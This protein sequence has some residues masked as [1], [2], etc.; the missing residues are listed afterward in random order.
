MSLCKSIDAKSKECLFDPIGG[1]G[2]WREQVKAC[3]TYS[4]P[5]YSVRPRSHTKAVNCSPTK[6]SLN[7]ASEMDKMARYPGMES[8]DWA[9]RKTTEEWLAEYETEVEVIFPVP[10]SMPVP[11]SPLFEPEPQFL[12]PLIYDSH[13]TTKD[14]W[15]SQLLLDTS[16]SGE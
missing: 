9:R 2:K 16:S 13:R 4:C 8:Q 7:L 15:T 5:L 3:T 1:S 12:T 6:R 11:Q 10:S 14:G